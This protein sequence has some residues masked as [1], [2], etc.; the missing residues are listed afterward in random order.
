MVKRQLTPGKS[1]TTKITEHE[2]LINE[3]VWRVYQC[4]QKGLKV[5]GFV[6]R[7][8]TCNQGDLCSS[9]MLCS[10]KF[11]SLRDKQSWTDTCKMGPTYCP[12]MLVKNHQTMPHNIP[13]E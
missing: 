7:C 8:K 9:V 10:T 12:E 11:P 1:V 2:I 6:D 13:E 5:K 3:L 4:L